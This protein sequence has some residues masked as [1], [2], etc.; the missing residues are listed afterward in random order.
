MSGSTPPTSF[1]PSAR[2]RQQSGMEMLPPL[3]ASLVGGAP[4]ACPQPAPNVGEPRTRAAS[5]SFSMAANHSL[6]EAAPPFTTMTSG[7][8]QIVLARATGSVGL[9]RSDQKPL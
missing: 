7:P 2:K 9:G 1:A 4:V 8:L 3:F 5:E 6:D